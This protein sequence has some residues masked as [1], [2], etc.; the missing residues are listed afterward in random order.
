MNL[1]TTNIVEVTKCYAL[2]GHNIGAKITI[3][4]KYGDKHN[5]LSCM[6]EKL[7]NGFLTYV[8]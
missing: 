6:T 8:A 7:Q 4:P 2:T 5:A 1:R 3:R